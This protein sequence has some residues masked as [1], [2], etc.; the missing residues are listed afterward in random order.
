[1]ENLIAQKYNVAKVSEFA[2]ILRSI[3]LI[4]ILYNTQTRLKKNVELLKVAQ[5]PYPNLFMIFQNIRLCSLSFKFR[6]QDLMTVLRY[7]T[8]A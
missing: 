6:G 8:V 5:N 2:K 3:G 7:I 4:S 1:V